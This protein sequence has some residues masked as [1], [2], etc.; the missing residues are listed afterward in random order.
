MNR[1]KYNI[2]LG[3]NCSPRAYLCHTN[4]AGESH[5]FDVTSI[6]MWAVN[7]LLANKFDGFLDQGQIEKMVMFNG[8]GGKIFT[9]KKYYVRLLHEF[10]NTK[11]EITIEKFME[12]KEK[13]GRRCKRLL[14]LFMTGGTILFWR[15][16]EIMDNR[17]MYDEY[18]DKFARGELD[19]LKK[20]SQFMKTTYPKVQFAVIY[21]SF[22]EGLDYDADNK[23]I[24][25]PTPKSMTYDNCKQ[26]IN[27]I[28]TSNIDFINKSIG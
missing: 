2:S 22:C 28:V 6:S 1:F 24:T 19:E 26:V 23:I 5:V 4:K 16:E 8:S 12:F 27:E 7:E 10:D 20:F 14:D 25:L 13:Y 18:K 15:L 21:L 3:C 9:Q 17:I 11:E